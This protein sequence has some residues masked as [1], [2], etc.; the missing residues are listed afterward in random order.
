[1]VKAWHA[2]LAGT[3]QTKGVAAGTLSRIAVPVATDSDSDSDSDSDEALRAA[4]RLVDE[5]GFD[6]IE[7][8]ALAGSWRREPGTPAYCIELTLEDL[9][10]GGP[11]LAAADRT[12][13]RLRVH[14]TA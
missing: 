13:P 4:M 14:V 9:R 11:A 10:P 3:Q 1:M 8:G 7:A 12:G 2:T 5:T 6:L